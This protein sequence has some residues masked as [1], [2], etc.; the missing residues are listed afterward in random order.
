MFPLRSKRLKDFVYFRSA[1]PTGTYPHEAGPLTEALSNRL[2][3]Y[4]IQVDPIQKHWEDLRM[5]C[6]FEGQL[7]WLDVTTYVEVQ[8][9][10]FSVA[11]KPAGRW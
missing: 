9:P 4:G 6:R 7:F 10:E 8:P 3:A 5:V 1:L 11:I 2:R